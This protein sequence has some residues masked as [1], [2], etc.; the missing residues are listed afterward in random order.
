MDGFLTFEGRAIS[1][2]ARCHWPLVTMRL[3]ACAL[4]LLALLAVHPTARSQALALERSYG[5]GGLAQ[6]DLGGDWEGAC[7]VL[8][9][10]DGRTLEAGTTNRPFVQ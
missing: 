6:S 1:R 7:C 3:T 2:A 10:A 4:T 8:V 5:V 9:R